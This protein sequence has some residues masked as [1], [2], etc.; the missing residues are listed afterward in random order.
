MTLVREEIGKY[1]DAYRVPDS[2]IRIE[3]R[4]LALR[5][6]YKWEAIRAGIRKIDMEAV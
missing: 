6:Y 5:E 2:A 1:I 4:E 3:K